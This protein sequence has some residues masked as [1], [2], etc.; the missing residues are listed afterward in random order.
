MEGFL[1]TSFKP[2]YH[3]WANQLLMGMTRCLDMLIGMS[4]FGILDALSFFD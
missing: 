3:R 1:E 4:T 2:L